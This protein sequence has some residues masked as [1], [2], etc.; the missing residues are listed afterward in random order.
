MGSCSLQ[1]SESSV[2]TSIIPSKSG[3]RF[4]LVLWGAIII[5]VSFG[6]RLC[7]QLSSIS[8]NAFA[9]GAF[10][11]T[12]TIAYLIFFAHCKER[13]T[14]TRQSRWMWF[15]SG[16]ALLSLSGV[17][18]LLLEM[19]DSTFILFHP[20][21]MRILIYGLTLT[22]VTTNLLA[23][24]CKSEK[25]FSLAI[26]WRKTAK[27]LLTS[28]IMILLWKTGAASLIL[29][30]IAS[31][32]FD[33]L[34]A[35]ETATTLVLL[36]SLHRI[37]VSKESQ[38]DTGDI[39]PICYW[40][41]GMVLSKGISLVSWQNQVG[42]WGIKAV[43]EFSAVSALVFG[44]FR[45]YERYHYRTKVEMD[46]LKSMD[47]I[48]WALVGAA[49]ISELTSILAQSISKSLNDCYVA[50]YLA[51]GQ[52]L[53]LE[54]AAT[55]KIDDPLVEV[56][57]MLSLKPQRRSGFH[58]GHTSRAFQ[59]GEMQTVQE[60]FSDVEFIP[61]RQA[62]REE[63]LVV[64]MPIKNNGSVSGVINVFLPG[65]K[66]VDEPKMSLLKSTANAVARAIENRKTMEKEYSSY[67][68]A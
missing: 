2:G 42:Y 68:A 11:S 28:L 30:S 56:G 5:G 38:L 10:H 22:G 61:W 20:I 17:G 19:H 15:S 59:T 49:S 13:Y 16:F 35:L 64:S 4:K 18:S 53:E 37:V 3:M 39:Y 6:T 51:T 52:E 31:T 54:I 57:R 25:K 34:Y 24:Y 67:L 43:L 29:R 45:D 36:A 58:N 60:V 41:V 9:H 1:E 8:R 65:A 63:G 27:L 23:V 44:L 21:A 7:L 32:G 14:H 50:I 62:A 46:N 48:S 26:G 33:S 12:S 66:T 47:S 40:V 55:H